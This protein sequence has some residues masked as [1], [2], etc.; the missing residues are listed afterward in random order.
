MV[1]NYEKRMSFAVAMHCSSA[2]SFVCTA[3]FALE[4]HFVAGFVGVGFLSLLSVGVSE[5]GDCRL[6]LRSLSSR[7][8]SVSGSRPCFRRLPSRH[9][10]SNDSFYDLMVRGSLFQSSDRADW[11]K[12]SVQANS[13]A[14]FAVTPNLNRSLK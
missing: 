2:M 9:D 10:Q 3:S 14:T 4:T 11:Y 5:T 1:M 12:V 8:H 6:N 13:N 7:V